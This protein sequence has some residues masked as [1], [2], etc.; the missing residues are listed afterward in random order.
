VELPG[1]K[2][3]PIGGFREFIEKVL[4]ALGGGPTDFADLYQDPPLGVDCGR[5]I[6][7]ISVYS[8]GVDSWVEKRSYCGRR[9]QTPALRA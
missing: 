3:V 8:P 7:S 4:K 6:S 1:V 9:L 2:V 5:F